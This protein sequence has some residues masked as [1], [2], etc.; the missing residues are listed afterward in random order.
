M[1]YHTFKLFGCLGA[2]VA[3]FI[4]PVACCW[5]HCHCLCTADACVTAV[6]CIPAIAGIPDVSGVHLVSDVLIFDGIPVIAAIPHV[7][8]VTAVA[9][10]PNVAGLAVAIAPADPGTPIFSWCFLYTVL[11][12]ETY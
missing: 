9:F 12:N 3:A 6:A 11:C 10:L 2:P 5:R 1:S 7:V 8:G 4:P